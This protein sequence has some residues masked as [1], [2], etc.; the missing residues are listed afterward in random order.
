MKKESKYRE[1]LEWIVLVALVFA[2][3]KI[4]KEIGFMDHLKPETSTEKYIMILGLF[5]IA[6]IV[7]AVHELGHLIAGLMNGFRFELFVVG[8]LGIRRENDQVKVYLNKNL[9]YYGGLAATS[10]RDDN[11]DNAK[12]FARVILAGPIASIL[13]AIAC[14]VIAWYIDKPLGIIFYSGGL[15]SIGI[16]F[17]TTIPSKT[18][19]FFTDRKRFQRLI[20]PGK[21]QMTEIA[22]LKIMG[23]YS[24]DNSYKNVDRE[25][26]NT[27]ISDD[28]PFI[29][30]FGLFNLICFKLEN[31]GVIEENVLKE[32]EDLSK[33]MSKSFVTVFN[34][35]VEKIRKK[36]KIDAAIPEVEYSSE[37]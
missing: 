8:P 11:R 31:N 7:L 33:N 29:K 1:Y 21:D 13:F 30:F 20:T 4:S 32:Y 12:K 37:T 27:L 9:G 26:I 34:K 14:F 3:F 18:G 15:I 16:F 19:M 17:A 6:F 22:M 23:K 25:D 2:L 24:K 28:V 36:M 35:E 5:I 10:P